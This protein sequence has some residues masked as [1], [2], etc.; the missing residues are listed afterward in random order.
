[1]LWVKILGANALE[2]WVTGAEKLPP[3]LIQ[4]HP[5]STQSTQPPG[6]RL[7]DG[8]PPWGL[9]NEH[10]ETCSQ[11]SCAGNNSN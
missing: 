7:P 3:Y 8:K 11:F 9:G 10:S 1:M 4:R 5:Q 6:Q 2:V